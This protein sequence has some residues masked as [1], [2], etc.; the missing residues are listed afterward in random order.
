MRLYSCRKKLKTQTDSYRREEID[1]GKHIDS[2][3]LLAR[4]SVGS[5]DRKADATSFTFATKQCILIPTK[6]LGRIPISKWK[7]PMIAFTMTVIVAG[8]VRTSMH[9]ARREAQ[10]ERQEKLD[11][12]AAARR[13]KVTRSTPKPS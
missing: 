12:I 5:L 1:L 6:M 7:M 2:T 9:A 11:Q 10:V 3:Q 13:A 4:I 8:Y